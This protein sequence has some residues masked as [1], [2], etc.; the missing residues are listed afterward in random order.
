MSQESIKN[1]HTSNIT[2]APEL[3]YDFQLSLVKL[4]GI[5]LKQDSVSFLHKKVV[6]FY[7]S[8][9]VYTWSKDLNTDF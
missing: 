2:F 3:I 7:I 9:I 8:Y 5:Y 4:K 1:P 6:N